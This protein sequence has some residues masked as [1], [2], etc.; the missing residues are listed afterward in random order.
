MEPDQQRLHRGWVGISGCAV[1]LESLAGTGAAEPLRQVT[2]VEII[3]RLAAIAWL[4]AFLVYRRRR[5]VRHTPLPPE[6]PSVWTGHGIDT[7]T[8]RPRLECVRG[9]YG[10]AP[11]PSPPLPESRR[12]RARARRVVPCLAYFRH[13]HTQDETEPRF[14]P[15]ATARRGVPVRQPQSDEVRDAPTE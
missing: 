11:R 8:L 7:R 4:G 2:T 1:L 10:A 3:I 5:R 13:R 6:D 14:A 9:D 15:D 12:Q